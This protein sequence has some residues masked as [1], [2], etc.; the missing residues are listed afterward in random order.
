M[1]LATVLI[2]YGDFWLLM[3]YK[4]FVSPD[5]AGIHECFP[6]RF[7]IATPYRKLKGY[8]GGVGGYTI[9]L[10]NGLVTLVVNGLLI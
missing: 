10:T 7:E 4:K 9:M 5:E 3:G 2:P 1:W 6:Q 8:S